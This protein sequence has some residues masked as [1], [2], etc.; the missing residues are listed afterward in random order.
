MEENSQEIRALT[1]SGVH[2]QFLKFFHEGSEPEGLKILD[3]GAGEGALTQKL[4]KM[5]HHMHACDYTP[6]AFKFSPVKC[7]GVDITL[8]LPYADQTFDRVIAIEV[9]EHVLDHESFFSE[10]SRILSPKGKLY[11][12]TPNIL[13]LKSRFRFLFRG[14]PFGFK[15]LDMNNHDG[16]QHVASL[17]LDQYNYLALKHGFMEGVYGIDQKQSTSRWLFIIF[18]PLMLLVQKIKGFSTIHNQKDLLLGRRLFI[19]FSKEK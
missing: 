6:H 5:G 13:S 1:K 2:T 8:A 17:S 10:V 16:M 11:I 14:F 19:V 7:D 18:Y 3:V 12:S 15:P 9:S 4:H